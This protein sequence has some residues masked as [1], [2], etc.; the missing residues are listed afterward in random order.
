MHICRRSSRTFS[1]F[2]F[3][4][5]LVVRVLIK[6]QV[7]EPDNRAYY[8]QVG[9]DEHQVHPRTRVVNSVYIISIMTGSLSIHIGPNSETW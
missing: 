6:L 3:L 5:I 1:T 8:D 9:Y 2:L 7:V 4:V